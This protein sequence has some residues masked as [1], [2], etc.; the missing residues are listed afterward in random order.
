MYAEE[1]QHSAGCFRTGTPSFNGMN[2]YT[3]TFREPLGTYPY[4]IIWYI[5]CVGLTGVGCNSRSI[6][7]YLRLIDR[8]SEKYGEGLRRLRHF[9]TRRERFPI[10]AV[11]E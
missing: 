2:L 5:K 4:H 7:W 9:Q 6:D 1:A 8:Q 3:G 11:T 10:H